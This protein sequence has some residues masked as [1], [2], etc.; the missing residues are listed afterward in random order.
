MNNYCHSHLVYLCIAL[1]KEEK[2]SNVVYL[3]VK[4]DL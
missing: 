3:S 4:F 2:N 1:V